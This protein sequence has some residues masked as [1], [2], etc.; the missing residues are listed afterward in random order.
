[1]TSLPTSYMR[2]ILG[3]RDAALDAVLR[4]SLLEHGMPTIQ[5]DDNAGRVLQLLTM[6]RR[7]RRALEIG[8]LFGYS[9]IHIARGLPEGGQ[10]TTLEMDPEAA[11]LARRNLRAA[12][13]EDRVE[14]VVGDALEHLAAVPKAS[15]GMAFIDADKKSYPA[16]LKAVYPLLEPGA[17]LIAD[18]AFAEGDFSAE[19]EADADPERETKAI[20]AYNRAVC[21][22]PRL[23]S[24]FIG[25]ENG[26][27]VSYKG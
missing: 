22:S 4:E 15:L 2:A 11:G 16:Y 5:V 25:T 19:S 12:G 10:L 26:L 3:P 1:M 21:R 14:V 20:H 24:A 17:L 7:P 18:D 8:T 13:V 27:M 6:L 23:F 9:T